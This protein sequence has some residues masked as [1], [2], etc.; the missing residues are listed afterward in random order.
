MATTIN[1]TAIQ[2]SFNAL[3]YCSSALQV[4]YDIQY[5]GVELD[6]T[7]RTINLNITSQAVSGTN[8]TSCQPQFVVLTGLQEYVNY[9]I[10]LNVTIINLGVSNVFVAQVRNETF[11]AGK[12]AKLYN[13]IKF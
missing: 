9:T 3:Q 13:I 5:T 2:V 4:Q 10:S 12:F 7:T 6:T 1:S 8:T 11:Q